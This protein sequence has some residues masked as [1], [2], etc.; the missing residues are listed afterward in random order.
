MTYSLPLLPAA[1]AVFGLNVMD[2]FFLVHYRSLA[3]VGS[4]SL[5]YSLGYLV[6]QSFAAP[7]A[8]MFPPTAAAYWDAGNRE[9]LQQLFNRSLQFICIIIIPAIAGTVLLGGSI[10]RIL[11]PAPFASAAAVVPIVM[12]GYLFTMLSHYY[13]VAL[14][15]VHRQ[16]IV[17][18]AALA[19]VLC[20]LLLNIALIPRY[21]AFGAGVATAAAFFVQLVITSAMSS[22]ARLL[23]TDLVFV[24]R[25]GMASAMMLAI[26][27]GF[28]TAVPLGDFASILVTVPS[29]IIVFL[30]AA[31]RLG[32]VNL[33]EL[34][35]MWSEL[36]GFRVNTKAD[37][38]I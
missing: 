31:W 26:I 18:L 17:T 33:P 16:D 34:R 21:S 4:Y 20:N 2:R 6:I 8:V 15:L 11:A 35:R 10:L 30:V 12:A 13:E 25:V 27:A 22:R 9:G 28:N 36:R 24:A 19:A 14:G 32:A 1:L 23:R 29:G 38:S 7:V 5:A 3:V 37:P